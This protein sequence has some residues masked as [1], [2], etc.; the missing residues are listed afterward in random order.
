V[1]PL[2]SRAAEPVAQAASLRSPFL[3]GS[4]PIAPVDVDHAGAARPLNLLCGHLSDDAVDRLWTEVSSCRSVVHQG[5]VRKVDQRPSGEADL[6]CGCALSL[7]GRRASIPVVVAV[8]VT[9]TQ[10]QLWEGCWR[11]RRSCRS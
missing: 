10:G 6:E 7:K 4:A 3:S 8:L 9:T 11:G 2:P 5:Q 1:P